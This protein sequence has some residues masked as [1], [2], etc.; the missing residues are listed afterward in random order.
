MT[1]RLHWGMEVNTASVTGFLRF[2]LLAKLRRWRP[3][4]YRFAQEQA[5]IERWLGLIEQAAQLSGDLALEVTECARL[6]KGYGDTHKRG[7]ENFRL[8]EDRVIRPVL[9]GTDFAAARPGRD[10]ERPDRGP[11][12]PGRRGADALP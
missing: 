6:I 12:R 3:T 4:S 9:A 5:A 7:S 2:W 8:I 11:G 10:G 1:E